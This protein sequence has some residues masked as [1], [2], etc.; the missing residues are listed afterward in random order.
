MPATLRF[1]DVGSQ[2][3][4][5]EKIASLIRK[6]S[7]DPRI[8]AAARALTRDCRSRDDMCELS[9]IY[10]AVKNGDDRVSWLKRGMRYVADPHSWDAFSSVNAIILDCTAGSCA[11]DCDDATILIGSLTAAL[12][13]M[14]GARAWGK[15]R[16]QAGEFQHVYAVAA[17]PK[18]GPWPN[19]R[20][21]AVGLDVTVERFDVG[22]EPEGGHV[23]TS[24]I[25]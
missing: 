16:N 24:W 9:A 25:Q 6:G 3:D 7:I 15:G 2:S 11:G 4:A 22:D 12:G 8:V 1:E 23:M 13:F 18:A 10:N 21:N 17:V 19:P 14:V 20:E 5:L